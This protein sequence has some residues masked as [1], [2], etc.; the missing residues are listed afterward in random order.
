MTNRRGY[1]GGA[2][3]ARAP[4]KFAH[5][6]RKKGRKR[7]ER[8]EEKGERREK[9]KEKR[10]KKERKREENLNTLALRERIK[11]EAEIWR[12]I[13]HATITPNMLD[14]LGGGPWVDLL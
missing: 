9:E 4:C 2:E 1:R 14:S 12:G 5:K 3:W 10:E 6:K 13:N 11:E 7:E 8:K